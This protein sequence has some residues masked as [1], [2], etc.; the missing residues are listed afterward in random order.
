MKKFI[1]NRNDVE[2]LVNQFYLRV[3]KD[4]LLGPVF[5]SIIEEKRWSHHLSKLADFWE[6]N[7]FGIR[8]YKGNPIQAHQKVDVEM[9]YSITQEHFG[10]W[11]HL[12]F[13]TIDTYF[14]PRCPR[15]MRAKEGSRRMATGQFM[16][17]WHVRPKVK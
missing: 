16:A 3:R 12:W 6:T 15:A 2:K 10:R 14:D 4:D 1:E 17:M 5:N 7:L 11:L 9:D 8:R 13:S